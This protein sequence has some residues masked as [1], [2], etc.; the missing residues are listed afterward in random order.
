MLI[1]RYLI[2][3][4]LTPFTA[5]CAVLVL[6]LT[7]YSTAHYL[8]DAVAGELP[9]AMVGRM[10]LL[11]LLLT[12]ELLIPMALYLSV[13]IGLGRLHHDHET[14]AMA[15]AGMGE[16]RLLVAVGWVGLMMAVVVGILA[17]QVRPWAYQQTYILKARLEAEFDL[18]QLQAG[19]FLM[20][21]ESGYTVYSEARNG[22]EP[23]HLE[24]VFLQQQEDQQIR[25]IVA[26][27]AERHDPDGDFPSLVF[28]DGMA[29]DLDL[30]GSVDRSLRFKDL[31]VTLEGYRR[32]PV[33]QRRKATATTE[34]ALSDDPE[35]IAE[36]QW[37]LSRPVLTLLLAALAVP[38][39]RSR[40]RQGRYA[41]AVLAVL[42][43]VVYFNLDG[44]ART[45][46]ERAVIPPTPGLWWVAGLLLVTLLTLMRPRHLSWRRG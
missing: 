41:R 27:E 32:V 17:L 43:C 24:R 37:R 9:P 31:N 5:I 38:L 1:Q 2:R 20:G 46:V 7:T 39:S 23:L 45:L 6:I 33:P 11:K 3:E 15:A 25:V 21:G 16:G 22:A 10:V 8:G 18:G 13:V 35:D 19:R 29:Y 30:E 40:P 42:V 28:R 12:L 4:I 44:L 34:L 14:M 36:W 26:R